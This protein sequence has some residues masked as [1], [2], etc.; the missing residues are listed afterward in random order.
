MAGPRGF[1]KITCLQMR[2]IGLENTQIV[3]G[4]IQRCPKR[5]VDIACLQMQTAGFD[6]Y[7][8]AKQFILGNYYLRNNKKGL[9]DPLLLYME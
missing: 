4:E 7:K 2:M 9:K 5:S 6:K 8:T 3:L 1:V